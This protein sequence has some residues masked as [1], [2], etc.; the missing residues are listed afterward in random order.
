[1]A[2]VFKAVKVTE[3]IYWVGAIDWAL[4][5]FHGYHT[6]RGTTYNAYLVLGDSI[7]LVDTVKAPFRE[8]MLARVAS[9]VEPGKIRY[10]VSNHSEMDH[11]GSLPAVIDEIKPE[12]VFASAKGVEA[13]GAHFGRKDVI[14]VA[15]G[16]TLDLGGVTLSFMET[17][18]LHWPDSM[19]T[20]VPEEALL[21]SQDGFGMHL[22]SSERFDDELDWGVMEYEGAKYYANIVLPYSAIVTKTLEKVSAARLKINII[23]P[24]HGPIWRRDVGRIVGLYAKWAAQKPMAKAVI[25]YDSMWGSTAMMARAIGESIAESGVDVKVMAMAGGHRSDVITELLCAGAFVVGS[26]TIN[27]GVFPTIADLLTYT[28]GLKP[29]N[30]VGAAFGSYGWSG[31][32]IGQVAEMLESMKVELIGQ[33][34]K[35]QYVPDE[36]ALGACKQL[37]LDVGA[38]V[39]RNSA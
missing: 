25:A 37:G 39:K 28:K 18:M 2:G 14:A 10:I 32:S 23:A 29:R 34:V 30:L 12:K 8:E 7:T 24:D 9:V 1:M 3:R 5:D 22:A 11:S 26:P 17:R 13:L 21:F 6:G 33:A 31:E 16:G 19:M 20:Y 36:C 35:A 15:D 38:K 27:N 4:R